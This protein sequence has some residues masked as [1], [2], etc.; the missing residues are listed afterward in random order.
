MDSHRDVHPHDPKTIRNVLAAQVLAQVLPTLPLGYWQRRIAARA[1][2]LE[3]MPAMPRKSQ[4]VHLLRLPGAPPIWLLSTALMTWGVVAWVWRAD[5]R[6][7]RAAVRAAVA[8]VRRD[9]RHLT[10]A[11]LFVGTDAE[12]TRLRHVP[13]LRLSGPAA[14][15][16]TVGVLTIDDI[17]EVL[18]EACGDFGERPEAAAAA[19]ALRRLRE[20]EP[21]P[22]DDPSS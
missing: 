14:R 7:E 22:C 13:Y 3:P 10:S 16:T 12:R 5:Q 19:D 17:V 6:E 2:A 18:A 8:R 11:V 21:A 4:G 20:F 9:G 1:F 15:V